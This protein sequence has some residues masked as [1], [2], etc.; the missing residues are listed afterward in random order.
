M[1]SKE[2]YYLSTVEESCEEH[3]KTFLNRRTD[4]MVGMKDPKKE[5][6]S[7]NGHKRSTHEKFKIIP[8]PYCFAHLPIIEDKDWR[9]IL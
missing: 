2:Q 1:K 7:H 5:T 6:Y 3:D 4:I 9:E 8:C